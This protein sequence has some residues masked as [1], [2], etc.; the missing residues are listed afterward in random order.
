MI[1]S[2]CG[3][4]LRW[5]L[6]YLPGGKPKSCLYHPNNSFT[7]SHSIECLHMHGRLQLP[8]SV[9]DN[10]SFILNKLPLKKFRSSHKVSAWSV[11]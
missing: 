9:E 5:Y 6:S 11:R 7:R 2:E 1:R 10:M 8:L 4:V 3:R